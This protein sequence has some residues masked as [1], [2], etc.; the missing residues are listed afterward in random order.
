MSFAQDVKKEIAHLKVDDECLK[1]ELYGYLK[2]KNELV[3]RNK[4]LICELKTNSL[5]IVRRITGIIKKIY[6]VEVEVLEK[7]RKNLD[8]KNIYV[9]SLNSLLP[10]REFVIT[11]ELE[12]TKPPN[13][14][15]AFASVIILI[16]LFVATLEFIT[17]Q[18]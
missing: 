13:V 14:K 9:I 8:Y 12:P 2:L 16:D 3:I 15:L 18:L 10:T 1:A 7:Q 5:F 6:K 17:S 4:S 11:P